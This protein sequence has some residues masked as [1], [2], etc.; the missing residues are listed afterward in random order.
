MKRY[1][2][3][4]NRYN[5]FTANHVYDE[6]CYGELHGNGR[7][8][9]SPRST[10]EYAEKYPNE[11]ELVEELKI[12]AMNIEIPEGYE[13]DKKNSTFDTI[14]LKKIEAKLP[15]TWEEL[16]RVK[17]Y[18]VDESTV[19][20]ADAQCFSVNKNIFPTREQAEA[21]I[22]LAQLLQLREVYRNG[23]KPDWTDDNCKYSI[24]LIKNEWVEN[25]Y[26]ESN[27]IFSF[28]TKEIKDQF[29]TNFKDLLE[30]VKP[31]FI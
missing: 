1:K 14:K 22:A 6:C 11:W 21:S 13:V 17:G 29:I 7:E 10:K 9:L 24:R 26:T 30:Q 20:E 12:K 18:Y 27:H 5:S 3:L 2:C 19:D 23:W 28:Q 8:G 25:W 31:L 15:K 16:K 4:T